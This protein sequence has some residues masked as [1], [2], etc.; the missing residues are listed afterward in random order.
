MCYLWTYYFCIFFVIHRTLT[1]KHDFFVITLLFYRWVYIIRPILKTIIQHAVDNSDLI[2]YINVLRCKLIPVVAY[3]RSFVWLLKKKICIQLS[4]LPSF[5]SRARICAFKAVVVVG[6][7]SRIVTHEMQLFLIF[8]QPGILKP[9][10][11]ISEHELLYF[12]I[13]EIYESI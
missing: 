5:R 4:I 9:G 8:A 2:L 3:P 1:I 10:V 11:N 7:I 6:C 13:Y 12:L